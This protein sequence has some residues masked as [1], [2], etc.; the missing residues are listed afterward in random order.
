VQKRMQNIFIILVDYEGEIITL[1]IWDCK[2]DLQ[3]DVETKATQGYLIRKEYTNFIHVLCTW[4][5]SHESA[6]PKKW[7]DKMLLYCLDNALW[8]L[9]KKKKFLGKFS[10]CHWRY[11]GVRGYKISG[12]QELL[13]YWTRPILPT[14]QYAS[15]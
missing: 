6:D 9:D 7:P 5:P 12:R 13:C 14:T 15:H 11:V 8:R 3:L 2:W 1:P 4:G 10:G